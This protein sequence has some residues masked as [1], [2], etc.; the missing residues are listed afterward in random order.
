MPSSY[1]ATPLRFQDCLTYMLQ[2]APCFLSP[3]LQAYDEL[4]RSVTSSITNISFQDSDP[5]WTQALLPVKHGGLRIRS[6]IQLAPSAF[7][8]SAAGSSGLV[9]HINTLQQDPLVA[10]ADALTRWSLGHNSPPATDS[11]SHSQRE[12][13]FPRIETTAQSLLKD[14]AKVQSPPPSH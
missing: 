2:T 3:E 4:L 5:A 6:A 9:S 11:A 14:A 8:A 10:R 7:L 12:W 1:S 13:D